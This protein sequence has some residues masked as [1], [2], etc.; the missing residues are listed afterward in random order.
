MNTKLSTRFMAIVGMLAA[1]STVLYYIG[2]IP[3]V[4]GF[5]HLKIDLSDLPAAVG[6]LVLG[7]LAGILIELV[8]NLLHLFRTTSMGIGEIANFLVGSALVCTMA[9]AYRRFSAKHTQGKAFSVAALLSLVAINV[10]GILANAILYPIFL[11]LIGQAMAT[12]PVFI[13]YLAGITWINT[14]KAIVTLVPMYP[15]LKVMNRLKLIDKLTN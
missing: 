13:A 15:L 14:F 8:K 5:E 7:P 11:M 9:V 1:L 6:G 2:E 12:L 4:P 3:I 10:V